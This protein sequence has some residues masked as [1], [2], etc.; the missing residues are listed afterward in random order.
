LLPFYWLAS[1]V[2]AWR[3]LAAAKAL[4][5]L[6]QMLAVLVTAIEANPQTTSIIEIP[7]IKKSLKQYKPSTHNSY[8]YLP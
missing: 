3:Q 4:V 7:D 1:V 2:P 8:T 6:P 5:T